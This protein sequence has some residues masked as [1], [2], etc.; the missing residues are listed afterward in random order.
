MSVLKWETAGALAERKPAPAKVHGQGP[1]T[2]VFTVL[3]TGAWLMRAPEA[4]RPAPRAERWAPEC[5]LA[6][7]L[8]LA[9]GEEPQAGRGRGMITH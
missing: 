2:P 1:P 3:A 4:T 8:S 9:G 5:R 6:V 7:S